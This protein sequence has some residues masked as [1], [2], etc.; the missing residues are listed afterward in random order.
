M[1]WQEQL[2]RHSV[3]LISLVIALT[4]LAYNTW[5][6][7]QTEANRN[8]RNAGF[9]VLLQLGRLDEVVFFNHYDMDAARGNPREGWAIV[10]VIRDLGGLM[11]APADQST[12]DLVDAWAAH[13]EGLGGDSDAAA[14][15]ISAAIE[16]TR[17]DVRT[18]MAA[19]D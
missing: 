15:S 12:A 14:D 13:W 16:R 7:E 18:V 4:S 1:H 8:V 5:R 6:N 19:L 17:A 10:L 11:P 3:A 2:K 9:E